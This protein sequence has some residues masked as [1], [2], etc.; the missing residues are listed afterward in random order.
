MIHRRLDQQ[1]IARYRHILNARKQSL[2]QARAAL[3]QEHLRMRTRLQRDMEEEYARYKQSAD[4]LMVIRR[5]FV[6]ELVSMF[7][8]RQVQ[9]KVKSITPPTGLSLGSGAGLAASVASFVTS[10]ATSAAAAM[11]SSVV[12]LTNNGNDSM[13]RSSMDSARTTSSTSDDLHEYRIVNV[14]WP[15]D[16]NYL[17]YPREKLNAGIGYVLHMLILL[18]NYLDVSLPFKLVNRGSKSYARAHNMDTLETSQMPLYLTDTNADS[19]TVGLSMLNFDIAYVCYTQGLDIPMQQVPHTLENLALICQAVHLG[20]DI[21]RPP[22]SL[23]LSH[24]NSSPLSSP[25]QSLNLPTSPTPRSTDLLHGPTDVMVFPF[26]LDFNKVV[27]LH[28]ALKRRRK[29]GSV[30]FVEPV[31][32]TGYSKE[33]LGD[34]DSEDEGEGDRD[35]GEW[36]MV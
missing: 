27:K 18:S 21:N 23:S 14:G 36:H 17:N 19:F 26:S 24:S 35:G 25:S 6:R 31:G 3:D 4:R 29:G 2:M 22:S 11:S 8:L 30:E 10:T 32:T 1:Q 34:T 16:R 7:R 12:S 28:M 15:K 9:R 5:G 13:V 33:L 20:W